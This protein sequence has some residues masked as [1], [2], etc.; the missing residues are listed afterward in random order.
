[1]AKNGKAPVVIGGSF[2]AIVVTGLLGWGDLRTQQKVN[3]EQIPLKADKEM[4]QM[5]IQ[6]QQEQLRVHT[7]NQKG[8][9]DRIETDIRSMDGKLD[10]LLEK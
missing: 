4:V 6:A 9:F 2:L 10:R 8:Q 3:T 1:M 7:D 5:Q